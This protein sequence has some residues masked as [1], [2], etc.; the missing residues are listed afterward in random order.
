M[1]VSLERIQLLQRPLTAESD[2]VDIHLP[3]WGHH[4]PIEPIER[5]VHPQLCQVHPATRCPS[6]KGLIRLLKIT[7]TSVG[8]LHRALARKGRS[9]AKHV[10]RGDPVER[11]RELALAVRNIAY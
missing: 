11:Q 1:Q 7:E 9:I 3:M 4:W 8:D 10:E 6:R 2:R 5:R